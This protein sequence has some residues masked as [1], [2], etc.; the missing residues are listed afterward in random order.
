[1]A[2]ILL[3]AGSPSVSSR[4]GAVLTALGERLAGAGLDA[5][6]L[7]VRDLP[8]ESLL[9]AQFDHIDIIAAVEAV[10]LAQVVIVA[11][12][13][14]KTSFAGVL[15]AFLD[16]LSQQALVNKVVLP[17]ATGGSP[18]HLL[19]IEYALKPVLAALGAQ[20]FLP[21]LYIQDAQILGVEPPQFTPEI[22]VRLDASVNAIIG[23][24]NPS[25]SFSKVLIS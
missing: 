24:R 6:I 4:S 15:K 7:R 22:E 19:A 21:A 20:T 16:L 18:A 11:T 25:V 5:Q 23:L 9:H 3:I 1:M 14:Y 12:P 8:A 10:S 2:D 17:I 13:I